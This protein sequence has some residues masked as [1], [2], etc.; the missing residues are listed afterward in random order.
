MKNENKGSQNQKD[1]TS[2]SSKSFSVGDSTLDFGSK[3]IEY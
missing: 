3:C 1:Y 2:K